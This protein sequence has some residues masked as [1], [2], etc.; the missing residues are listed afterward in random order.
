MKFCKNLQQ[1]VEI[2]DPEW[3]PYWTNYKMLKVRTLNHRQWCSLVCSIF[4]SLLYLAL[5]CWIDFMFSKT[6]IVTNNDSSFLFLSCVSH[7][8]LIILPSSPL[9]IETHQGTSLVGPG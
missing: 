1:I 9:T 7:V 8:S 3:A 4:L 6:R 5:E 2:S